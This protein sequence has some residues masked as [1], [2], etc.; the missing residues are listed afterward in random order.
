MASTSGC[1]CQAGEGSACLCLVVISIILPHSCVS[2][3]ARRGL[4]ACVRAPGC[5]RV[6]S[7][8]RLSN[9]WCS[10]RCIV[11]VGVSEIAFGYSC[12]FPVTVCGGVSVCER[13]PS[14]ECLAAGVYRMYGCSV[15]GCI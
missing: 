4:C 8:W 3:V 6:S 11:L 7:S 1:V 14:S 15:G 10:V 9:Y 2:P 12:P 5:L 13:H